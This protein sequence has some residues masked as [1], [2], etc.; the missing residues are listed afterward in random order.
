MFCNRSDRALGREAVTLAAAAVLSAGLLAG[1]SGS[2]P[3]SEASADAGQIHVVAS[4][5]PEYDWTRNIIGDT[6]GAELSL[7]ID[8]GTDMHSF[9]PAASDIL[10]ISS[11]DLFIYVGGESDAWVED[12]LKEPVNPDIVTVNLMEILGDAAYEENEEELNGAAAEEDDEEAEYDEHVWLSIRNARL[13]CS[14]ITEAL[15][16]ADPGNEDAYRANLAAYDAELA[17]LEAAYEEVLSPGG[18]GPSAVVFGDR[19]PFRYL[20][21]DYGIEYYAAFEGCSAETDASFE[22]IIFLAGKVD[23][24]GLNTVLT[25]DGSDGK[26]AQTIVNNTEGKDQQILMLD[27]MQSVSSQQISEGI[28]YISAMKDNLEVLTKCSD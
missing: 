28:S 1:C 12:V 7:L 18:D 20:M 27:S 6:E 19:F 3:S 15:C 23:E 4:I 24:L 16:Q 22:T 10:E 13:F 11:S 5:F 25:I 14:E 21:K 26:I 9:Q 17:E 2:R 8:S